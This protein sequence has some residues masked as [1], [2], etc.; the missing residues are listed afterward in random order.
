MLP[1]LDA[2]APAL[3]SLFGP[4]ADAAARS[5][6]F[7]QRVRVF[8]GSSFLRTCV[9]TWVADS[10]ATLDRFAATAASLGLDVSPQ[11]IDQRLDDASDFF[12][13]MLEQSLQRAFACSGRAL[14]LLDRFNGVYLDDCTYVAL[15]PGLASSFPGCGGSTPEAGL[16]SLKIL[17]R[18]EAS[19]AQPCALR[20]CL[21][22][23]GDPELA[24]AL[25]PLPRRALRLGDLGFFKLGSLRGMDAAGV[26]F[27]T[28]I[29][30]GTA[31]RVEGKRVGKRV[32]KRMEG[33]AAWLAEQGERLLDRDAVLGGGRKARVKGRLVAWR[34]S[35]EKAAERREKLRKEAKDKGYEASEESLALCGWVVLFTNV[36]R[37][38]L[39]AEEVG[40]VYRVRWQ[41]ELVFK[42][43]KSELKVDEWRTGKP[44][45]ILAEVYGKLLGAVA[46]SWLALQAWSE[47]P[48]KGLRRLAKGMR[49]AAEKALWLLAT[50]G[51]EAMARHLRRALPGL[52]RL[53]RMPRR[54]KAKGTVQRLQE[55]S[56]RP[57]HGPPPTSAPALPPAEGAVSVIR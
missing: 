26:F 1:T 33:L 36:P 51:P 20:V 16:A 57:V 34:Q 37:T 17:L 42:T 48:A 30:G 45:R 40:E 18:W 10:D 56:E 32:G 39:S 29:K 46:Q 7:V 5:S 22:R 50:E 6:G 19:S 21:A 31:L 2:L 13:L 3:Q 14:P 24:D 4:D 55:A 8:S 9:F 47:G 44:G 52:R 53:G 41:V 25:P 38:I 23:R 54:R 49:P 43:W 27:V 35:E 11:A 28:K 12:R 15:P